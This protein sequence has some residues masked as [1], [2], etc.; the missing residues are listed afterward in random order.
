MA[1]PSFQLPKSFLTQLGE[2]TQGYFLVTVNEA[3]Q[4][5]SF[6]A[7]DSP[8]IRLGLFKFS[9]LLT[10]TM[11]DVMTASM[12]QPRPDPENPDGNDIGGIAFS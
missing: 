10:N 11:E 3:G 5:E 7:A 8:V 4:F 2:F 1:N 12:S 6:V 9:T